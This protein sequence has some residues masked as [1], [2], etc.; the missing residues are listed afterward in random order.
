MVSRL[1][2]SFKNWIVLDPWDLAVA[3]F[4]CWPFQAAKLENLES[5]SFANFF[6]N[7]P[8]VNSWDFDLYSIFRKFSREEL[9][10]EEITKERINGF[11]FNF[12]FNIYRHSFLNFLN[13]LNREGHLAKL[14]LSRAQTRIIFFLC[15]FQWSHECLSNGDTP[16]SF[17]L[18]RS[19]KARIRR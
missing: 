10:R 18:A 1:F 11:K 3:N 19:K 9:M 5:E 15:S 6:Q 13:F 7:F 8:F 12:S 16:L 4:H 14:R 2:W 17:S